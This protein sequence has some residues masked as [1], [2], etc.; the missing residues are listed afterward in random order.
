MENNLFYDDG[1]VRVS[2]TMFETPGTQFPI[3]NIAAVRTLTESPNRKGP[4]I[5]VVVGVLLLGA[6]GLGLIG[7]GLGVFWWI[8][9]KDL[10]YIVV[11]SGGADQ[12][13]YVSPD[14]TTI[15]KIQS[16]INSA[17]ELH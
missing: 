2:R 5:C 12:K 1:S 4:I 3:R 14:S 16:A 17:L 15:R 8:S 7:I 13:A 9:Q 10:Y 11:V 6:Y